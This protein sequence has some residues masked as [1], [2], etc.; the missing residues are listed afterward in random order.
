MWSKWLGKFV[1]LAIIMAT[2]A[3]WAQNSNLYSAQDLFIQHQ[4][5]RYF[6]MPE[7]ARSMG[8]AGSIMATANGSESVFGN[9][10]GLGV[11]KCFELSF[12]YVHSRMSGNEFP[13][14]GVGPETINGGY[15]TLILPLDRGF[16]SCRG[17]DGYTGEGKCGSAQSASRMP[18]S[19]AIGWSGY[20]GDGDDIFQTDTKGYRL[21][22]AYGIQYNDCMLLGAAVTY[23]NDKD[24]NIYAEYRMD[25]GI[26]GM[27][28]LQ[29]KPNDQVTFGISGFY[30]SGS[31][32][33]DI[34][35]IGEQSGD[36]SSSG[37]DLGF[38]YQPCCMTQI[39]GGIDYGK[40]D[41]SAKIQN[42][43]FMLDER[44]DERGDAWN[45]RFGLEQCILND[46]LV[47]RL[48]YRYHNDDYQFNNPAIANDLSGNL[49]YH[50]ISSGLGLNVTKCLS[51]D[52]GCEYRFVNDGDMT[53]M[54][55]GT[56][57]F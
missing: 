29:L 13:R 17:S 39:F 31:P 24:R 25:D 46:K 42:P 11:S 45:T 47:G 41:L 55:S 48:G 28:G 14:L 9:P 36:R 16:A 43:Q 56:M 7:T 37:F 44:T 53:N 19:F 3:S 20:N 57:H 51:I 30:A 2:E 15:S 54:I 23:H 12:G 52:Y 34:F 38:S 35:I 33:S 22:F 5:Q 27:L 21:H 6:D 18:G 1:L 8:T 50:A 4:E 26:R 32:N 10:A 49:N 40:Y